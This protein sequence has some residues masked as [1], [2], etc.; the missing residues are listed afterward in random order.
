MSPLLLFAGCAKSAAD[1][2]GSAPQDPELAIQSGMHATK[3]SVG[4]VYLIHSALGH[5]WQEWEATSISRN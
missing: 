5:Q 1:T 4:F 3:I 2:P